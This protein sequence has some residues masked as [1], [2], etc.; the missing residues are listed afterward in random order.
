MKALRIGISLLLLGCVAVQPASANVVGYINRT[1]VPGDNLIANQLN[2][3]SGNTINNILMGVADGATFTKWNP[4]AS[5]FL[6]LSIFNESSAAWSIN[7]SL[8]LG[9]GGLLS[10]PAAT[11]NT[12]V[13]EVG[14]YLNDPGPPRQIGWNPAY[15]DGLH[16]I[17]CPTPFGNATF[18]EVVG[19]A[20][21]AGEW[22]KTLN[23]AGQTY[24]TTTF[25]GSG[26]DNGSP[27]LVVGQAA[28]FN[29]GPVPEPSALALVGMAGFT[30]LG[31]RRRRS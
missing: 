1:I 18:D 17:S 14:P 10:S 23:E 4:L 30:M 2:A 19:R 25:D 28:W 29:L 24:L 26:W 21:E 6:P 27:S 12:F 15:A 8:N 11:I 7:Y 22:V 16:L 31:L 20:P 9:E 13:G 3:S 5:T